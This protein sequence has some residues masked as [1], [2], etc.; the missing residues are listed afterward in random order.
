MQVVL[1]GVPAERAL[2]RELFWSDRGFGTVRTGWM[3]QSGRG[4]GPSAASEV[5]VGDV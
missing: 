4:A 1:V 3:A 2:A 5:A